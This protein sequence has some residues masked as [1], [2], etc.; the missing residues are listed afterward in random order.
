MNRP[1]AYSTFFTRPPTGAR[2]TWTSSGDRKID[3]RTAGP[4]HGSVASVTT[5]T[6]PSAGATT[7][8]GRA[9][10]RPL[11]ITEEAETGQRRDQEDRGGGPPAH[12]GH[13]TRRRR[14]GQDE[15]PP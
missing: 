9:G 5:I 6:R 11:G 2:F 1:G 10:G 7:A 14:E 3:T 13:D 8:P 15:R 4:T 12:P